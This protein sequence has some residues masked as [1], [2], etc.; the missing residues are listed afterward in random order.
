[1]SGCEGNDERR[2]GHPRENRLAEARETERE[3]NAGN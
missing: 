1:M 2:E 3:K